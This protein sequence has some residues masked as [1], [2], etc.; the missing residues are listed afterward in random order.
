MVPLSIRHW[1]KRGWVFAAGIRFDNRV[2]PGLGD[3]RPQ[4]ITVI[5]RVADHLLG[6]GQ[7]PGQQ[8]GRLRRVYGLPRREL[9]AQHLACPIPH[10]MKFARVSAPAAPY[11][12]FPVFFPAPVP[13]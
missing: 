11:R 9:P 7:P 5:C 6:R 4:R 2:R 3:E 1:V 8:P 10:H 13:C 12:L